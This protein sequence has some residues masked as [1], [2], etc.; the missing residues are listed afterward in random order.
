MNQMKLSVMLYCLMIIKLTIYTASG[1][2]QVGFDAAYPGVVRINSEITGEKGTGV[3]I[4]SFEPGI[5]IITNRHVIWKKD[6]TIVSESDI[7]Q[8]TTV[9]FTG[10]NEIFRIDKVL[11]QSDIKAP[12]LAVL[13]LKEVS[14]INTKSLYLSQVDRVRKG[15]R[16]H[17]IAYPVGKFR[18]Q[19][20]EAEIQDEDDQYYHCGLRIDST[21]IRGGASGSP[22]LDARGI[23]IGLVTLAAGGKGQAIKHSVIRD[24]LKAWQIKIHDAPERELIAMPRSRFSIVTDDKKTRRV[25]QAV[26]ERMVYFLNDCELLDI[27]SGAEAERLI[28]LLNNNLPGLWNDSTVFKLP[29]KLLDADWTRKGNKYRIRF[30]LKNVPDD[31][32]L[33]AEFEVPDKPDKNIERLAEQAVEKF[34]GLFEIQVKFKGVRRGMLTKWSSWA[35][36]SLAGWSAIS[37]W[38]AGES[39]KDYDRALT[40]SSAEKMF[41]RWRNYDL[42]RWICGGLALTS[43]A[44]WSYSN[45]VNPRRAVYNKDKK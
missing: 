21:K 45:Y 25:V 38:Q 19:V 24:V 4:K 44:T 32:L 1:Y 27:V 39:E 7:R 28:S 12:D 6:T 9:S 14:G 16:V 30:T 15:S 31:G 33:P 5:V 36:L 37:Y 2:T 8:K 3:I 17:L 22:L 43:G 26:Y 41:T 35:A 10:T 18:P 40:K 23:V 34:V 29:T 42:S 13:Y 20:Y 11:F